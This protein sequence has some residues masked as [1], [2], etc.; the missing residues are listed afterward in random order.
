MRFGGLYWIFCF[1]LLFSGLLALIEIIK[2]KNP[3]AA[4]AIE[5]VSGYA[6]YIGLGA[7]V[8]AILTL[9][10]IIKYLSFFFRLVPISTIVLI[11]AMVSAILL[12]IF[13]S[14]DLFKS[15]G[16]LNKE[17]GDALSA[18]LSG[19]KI[20]LGFAGAGSAL[21]LLLWR[22]VGWAF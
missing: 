1:A 19:I 17:K 13:Q 3:Q 15:W 8:T 7:M 5:K 20:P 21:Y 10:Q 4:E 12:G 14:I 16:I 18:K 22:L 6:G 9:L 11:V 2:K